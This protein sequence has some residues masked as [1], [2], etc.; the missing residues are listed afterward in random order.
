MKLF[1]LFAVML[2]AVALTGC[3]SGVRRDVASEAPGASASSVKLADPKV[4]SVTLRMSDAAKERYAT[5]TTFNPEGLRSAV[6]RMLQSRGLLSPDSKQRMDIELVSFRMRSQFSAMM[7]G[8]MAGADNVTGNVHIVGP[9]GKQL[10]KFEVS[11]SYALGG[12]G[13]GPDATRMGW[14]FEEFAKLTTKEL[15]GEVD[16]K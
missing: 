1:E 10:T 3:A 12:V 5:G 9:D 4:A 7:W 6:E 8:V 15:S 11:A 2:L 13:G 14:L 16:K